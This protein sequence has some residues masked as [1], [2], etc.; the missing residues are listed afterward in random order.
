MFRLP[1]NLLD[2]SQRYLLIIDDEPAIL[3]ALQ[4]ALRLEN[5]RILTASS[6][7]EALKLLAT[8]P[9]DVVLSDVR[10]ADM[11]G[12]DFLRKIKIIHPD[13]VRMVLSGSS[14]VGSVLKAINEGVMYRFF[15]KPWEQDDL[16]NQLRDAFQLRELHRENKRMRQQLLTQQ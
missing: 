10:L 15:S 9:V 11:D 4:R 12:L 3:A 7:T 16:R 5:Y 2:E 14:E 8:H 13:V 6:S 1:T